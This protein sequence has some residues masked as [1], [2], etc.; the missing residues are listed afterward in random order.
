MNTSFASPLE[1][2]EAV[3]I[4]DGGWLC[5]G[6]VTGTTSRGWDVSLAEGVRLLVPVSAVA[7]YL[8]AHL[9]RNSQRSSELAI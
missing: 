9:K 8:A 5:S 4:K 3:G 7:T 1:A 2:L 6:A